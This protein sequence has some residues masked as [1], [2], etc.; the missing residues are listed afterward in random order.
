[1]R[2]TMASQ[3]PP[4]L[5][6]RDDAANPYRVLITTADGRIAHRFANGGWRDIGGIPMPGTGPSAVASGDFSAYIVMNGEDA[7]GCVT[8]CV[9]GDSP[10][11]DTVARVGGL[12]LRRFE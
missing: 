11:P 4:A 6:K 3:S 7:K 2:A 1:L 8:S 9:P 5:T 10:W 12:W